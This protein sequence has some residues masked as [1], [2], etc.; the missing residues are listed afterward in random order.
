MSA[1][2]LISYKGSKII[3]SI[4]DDSSEEMY[5]CSVCAK[6]LNPDYEQ[7]ICNFCMSYDSHAYKYAQNKNEIDYD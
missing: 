7:W 5:I 3:M 2:F 6:N 1:P 4:Q